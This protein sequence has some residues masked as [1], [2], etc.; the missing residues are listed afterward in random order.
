VRCLACHVTNPRDFRDPALGPVTRSAAATDSAIGCERCHGP[1]SNHIAAIEADMKDR[2]IVNVGRA[3]AETISNDC[4]QC[5]IVGDAAEIRKTPTDPGWVRSA[6]L[7][8]TFSRCYTE[9]GGRFSCLTC[10]DPHRDSPHEATFYEAKCLE[11]HA[12]RG[13]AGKGATG[14][15]SVC[16][17]NAT[18]DCLKCHMPKLPMPV[19]HTSLT[20]HFIRVREN[21]PEPDAGAG[22]EH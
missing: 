9:S 2:A 20:D 22:R 21:D 12:P 18:R 15:D 14:G 8:F 11:C 5:H 7:T 10:H 3:S 13:E 6:G 4:I 17:V 1:G 16:K 19:L